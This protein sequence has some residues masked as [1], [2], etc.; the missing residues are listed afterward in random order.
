MLF[1]RDKIVIKPCMG[2]GDAVYAYPTV[3]YYR[4]KFVDKKIIVITEHK[5]VYSG[6]NG[7][8]FSSS[9][10]K[11]DID[12]RYLNRKHINETNQFQDV[13]INSKTPLDTKFEME[14][15]P[16][17]PVV[18]SE[19]RILLVRNPYLGMELVKS[20]ELMPNFSFIKDKI[21][22]LKKQYYTILLSNKKDNE[23]FCCDFDMEINRTTINELLNLIKQSDLIISQNG[24]ILAMAEAM[25]KKIITVFSS[26]L[27]TTNDF[28]LRSITP[29][30]V[31]TKSTSKYLYDNEE[32]KFGD[33]LK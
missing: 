33:L 5:D 8:L 1:H 9:L 23:I 2:L 18:K 3:N 10:N 6:I 14:V 26:K 25:E 24:H 22:T 16:K 20:P 32:D 29:Q 13:L 19:K 27:K 28:F 4:K 7:L 12:C 15:F 17:K 21:K 30:K 11:F 31:I